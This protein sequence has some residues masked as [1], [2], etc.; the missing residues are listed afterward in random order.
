MDWLR[1]VGMPEWTGLDKL[2]CRSG[3]AWTSWNVGMDCLGQ[4]EMS[5]WNGLDKMECRNGLAWTSRNLG[6]G[7]T[8]HGLVRVP[9]MG[10]LQ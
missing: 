9:E 8:W 2:E 5:E 6:N 1:Q 10:S 3:L 4:D 7:L